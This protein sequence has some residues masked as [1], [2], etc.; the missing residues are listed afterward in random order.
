MSLK[1]NNDQNISMN[2]LRES[3]WEI[4]D[5]LKVVMESVTSLEKEHEKL[6]NLSDHISRRIK[7]IKERKKHG[8]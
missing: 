2:L 6:R 5:K 4:E 3:I 1:V 7:K 8:K